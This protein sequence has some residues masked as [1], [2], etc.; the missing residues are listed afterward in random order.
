MLTF[1]EGLTISDISSKLDLPIRLTKIII[2]EFIETQ[3]FIEV[4][5]INDQETTYQPAISDSKLTVKF[6]VN[7]LDEKGVN[8]LPIENTADL[9][10]INK[11]MIELDEVLN[12]SKGNM[13][14]KD[15]K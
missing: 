2:A 15:L 5:T 3:I 10:L 7:K 6:I 12:T 13:L 1:F 14:V 4:K 11:L 9:M 8:E